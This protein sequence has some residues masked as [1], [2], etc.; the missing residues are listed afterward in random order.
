MNLNNLNISEVNTSAVNAPTSK[1]R[2]IVGVS[3][4]LSFAS[5]SFAYHDDSYRQDGSVSYDYAKVI[6]VEPIFEAYTVAEPIEKCWDERVP[7]K[8]QSR[9]KSYTPEIFGAIIGAAVGNRFGKGSGRDAATVAGAVLGGS[10]ARDVKNNKRAQH[11]EDYGHRRYQ[12][13]QR[14]EVT[15]VYRTE[16]QIVGY[17]VRYRYRGDVYQTTT[18]HEPGDKIKLK[19]SFKPV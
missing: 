12:V 10:I 5:T 8:R 6:N 1:I 15:D 16:Q 9:K 4:L 18:D 2:L 17:D 19:I 11:R 14:C 3:A 13:V 7:H